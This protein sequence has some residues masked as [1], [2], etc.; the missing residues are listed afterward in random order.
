MI[1]KKDFFFVIVG[2]AGAGK[3]TFAE[4]VKTGKFI[5]SRQPSLDTSA[6]LGNYEYNNKIYNF[7]MWD[8][9]GNQN[10]FNITK[11]I[12]NTS[13]CILI[14]FN[15]VLECNDA[16][17]SMDELEEWY[18]LATKTGMYTIMVSTHKDM[19]K[20]N[21]CPYYID[22]FREKYK[23][24]DIIDISS[25]TGENISTVLDLICNLYENTPQ[26]ARGINLSDTKSKD[27]KDED[28]NC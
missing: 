22:D 12:F 25:K 15:P 17:N 6:I 21:C 23:V 14:F 27:K 1:T 28:C 16:Q 24:V 5:E 4:R 13:L 10:W 8:T 19:W 7:G 18:K 2:A 11:D 26:K 20:N 3:S 9:P